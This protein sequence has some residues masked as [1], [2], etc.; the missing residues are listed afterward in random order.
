[1]DEL[2]VK[3]DLQVNEGGRSWYELRITFG[4]FE[5]IA[6]GGLT[7]DNNTEITPFLG[8]GVPSLLASDG[9]YILLSPTEAVSSISTTRML[10]DY[11][12]S[13]SLK[14]WCF[15]SSSFV[16][17]EFH[18]PAPLSLHEN[19]DGYVYVASKLIGLF[20]TKNIT[21]AEVCMLKT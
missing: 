8:V 10:R 2:T 13:Q 21:M 3:M 16:E 15:K 9:N 14:Q 12:R 4:K 20:A 11:Q 18:T 5:A 1:M 17:R 19:F 6:T 7:G